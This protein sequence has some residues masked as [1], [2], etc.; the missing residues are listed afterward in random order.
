M[1]KIEEEIFKKKK[2]IFSKMEEFGFYKEKEHYIYETDFMDRDFR[3][4]LM[5]ALDGKIS[6]E[7]IDK[8]N[9]EVYTQL[10]SENFHGSYVNSVR[11]SYKQVL[12]AIGA[13]VCEDVLFSSEQANRMTQF[14]EKMYGVKPDFPFQQAKHSSYGVFRH[15]RSKKWFALIMEIKMDTLLKNGDSTTIDVINLKTDAADLLRSL[16]PNAIFPGYHMNHKTWISII[17]NHSLDDALVMSF[18]EKSYE[19]T[20]LKNSRGNSKGK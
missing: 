16:Y 5:V 14:I 1:L 4:R 7:V 19:L 15:G 2:F 12:K 8:I 3:L 20:C 18:I 9:N 10:H 13:C 11:A 17:L 6:V